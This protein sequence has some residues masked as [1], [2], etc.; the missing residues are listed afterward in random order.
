[1]IVMVE[2]SSPFGPETLCLRALWWFHSIVVEYSSRFRPVT[3]CWSKSWEHNDGHCGFMLLESM[4]LWFGMLFRPT[5]RYILSLEAVNYDYMYILTSNN[6]LVFIFLSAVV[7]GIAQVW[8][9]VVRHAR[10]YNYLI[11]VHNIW[12][13]GEGDTKMEKY[14]GPKGTTWPGKVPFQDLILVLAPGQNTN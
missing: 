5:M 6:T 1:M 14:A 13:E 3:L 11:G 9:R 10:T 4:F 12:G 7:K 8:T 2:H